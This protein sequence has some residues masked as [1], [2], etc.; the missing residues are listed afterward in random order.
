MNKV[1]LDVQNIF[2]YFDQNNTPLKVLENLLFL[3]D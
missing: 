1:I 2:K 3:E